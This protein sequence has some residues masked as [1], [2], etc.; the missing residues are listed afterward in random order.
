MMLLEHEDQITCFI[1]LL[2]NRYEYYRKKITDEN[3]LVD[4]NFWKIVDVA[5]NFQS[6]QVIITLAWYINNDALK[7]ELPI[8]TL[9]MV[10]DTQK[11]YMDIVEKEWSEPVRRWVNAGSYI[12]FEKNLN[13]IFN[14]LIQYLVKTNPDFVSWKVLEVESSTSANIEER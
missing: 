8:K 4:V 13:N 7:K 10:K 12:D 2:I 3:T 14:D 6:K 5:F 9:K 1:L 11:R